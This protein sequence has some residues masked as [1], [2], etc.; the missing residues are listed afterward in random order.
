MNFLVDTHW[1]ISFLNRR[2]LAVALFEE[3]IPGGIAISVIAFGEVLEGLPD[4][5]VE[6][7]DSQRL[8][9]LLQRV[10][11]LDINRGTA[12][13]FAPLRR[14]LRAQ[15]LL[16]AD[17][18]IWIAATAIHF[19]LILVSRDEHFQRIPDLRLDRR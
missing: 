5:S 15:G 7:A 18:D 6:P 9:E 4:V 2:P 3:L 11:L 19:D 13:V 1:V 10:D 8:S 14:S 12:E 16:L 17:N